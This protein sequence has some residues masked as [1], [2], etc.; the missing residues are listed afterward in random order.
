MHLYVGRKRVINCKLCLLLIYIALGKCV[1][2]LNFGLIGTVCVRACMCVC[3]T[4]WLVLDMHI[5]SRLFT[6]IGQRGG[7]LKDIH[8]GV[9]NVLVHMLNTPAW[10]SFIFDAS[11][12]Y[13][14][15]HNQLQPH[16]CMENNC[17]SILKILG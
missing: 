15:R 5:S 12:M 7:R 17:L 16:A 14:T 10:M 1:N 11:S 13:N 8:A 4:S 6:F 3:K 9:F 2:V